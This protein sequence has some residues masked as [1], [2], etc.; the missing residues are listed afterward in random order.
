MNC[1][2]DCLKTVAKTLKQ[3]YC[4]HLYIMG[5]KLVARGGIRTL[6]ANL[7][8]SVS[9]ILCEVRMS[10]ATLYINIL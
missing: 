8:S 2:V 4:V 10:S 1:I 9:E 7:L 6:N 3:P 5:R